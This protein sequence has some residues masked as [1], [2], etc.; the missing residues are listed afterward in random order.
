MLFY[1]VII[2][3]KYVIRTEKVEKCLDFT[4]MRKVTALLDQV[5][6]WKTICN[7]R[8]FRIKCISHTKF[9]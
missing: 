8:N 4:E 5:G 3:I 7:R 2:L 6:P 1:S 9:V